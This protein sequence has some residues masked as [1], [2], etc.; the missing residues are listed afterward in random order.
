[1]VTRV[2]Q[3]KFFEK[4]KMIFLFKWY[5][6]SNNYLCNKKNVFQ[7]SVNT[8]AK[9]VNH[10]FFGQ[11]NQILSISYC[12]ILSKFHQHVVQ[13]FLTSCVSIRISYIKCLIENHF[14][15]VNLPLKLFRATVA[16]TDIGSLKSLHTLFDRYLNLMM[17]KF[18]QNCMVPNIQNFKLFWEKKIQIT[19][20][21][22]HF[23]R[24]FCSW[25]LLNDKNTMNLKTTIVHRFKKYDS[26]TRAT[27]SPLQSKNAACAL[28]I[29]FKVLPCLLE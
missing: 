5:L 29:N 14:F 1:M 6:A 15:R 19:N 12:M 9:M 27:R 23:G 22:R 8:F 7:N 13:R 3:P 16:N 28:Q 17:V 20:C 4:W 18:E 21:W 11:K 24:R 2:G 25:K 26:L 10:F